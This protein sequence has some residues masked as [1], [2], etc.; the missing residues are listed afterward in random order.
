MACHAAYHLVFELAYIAHEAAELLL[1]EGLAF[2]DN[3]YLP[4]FLIDTV[5]QMK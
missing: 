3:Q 1:N 5:Q 2:L 4:A